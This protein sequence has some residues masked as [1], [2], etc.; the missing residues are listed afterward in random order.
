MNP[1]LDLTERKEHTRDKEADAKQQVEE[2]GSEREEGGLPKEH[3]ALGTTWPPQKH[4]GTWPH[5]PATDVTKNSA[6]I[7]P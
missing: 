4:M 2:L 6:K 1:S 7:Y 3:M 5:Y